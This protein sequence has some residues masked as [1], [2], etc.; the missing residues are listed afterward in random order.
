MK[1]YQEC[2]FWERCGRWWWYMPEAYMV[3]VLYILIWNL[4][5][6]PRVAS[7]PEDGYVGRYDGAGM[8]WAVVM[9]RYNARMG[10][11]K[12]LDEIKAALYAASN[13]DAEGGRETDSVQ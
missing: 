13:K 1:R 2:G 6:K 12:T 10:R 9:A 11:V 7:P 4:E 8:I 3:A 5:G